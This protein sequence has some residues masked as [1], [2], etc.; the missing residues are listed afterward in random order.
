LA[1]GDSTPT[2]PISSIQDHTVSDAGEVATFLQ[3]TAR[4]DSHFAGKA[5]A[6]IE[7]T[8]SNVDK[9]AQFRKGQKLTNVILTVEAIIDSG[10][11]KIGTDQTHTFS[12]AV[13]MEKGDLQ[14]GNEDSTPATRTVTFALSRFPDAEAD[15]T[16]TIANAS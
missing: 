14:H 2:S 15:P 7:I 4:V 8:T 1:A 6:T 5:A 3:G 12:S 9:V 13:V 16:Y 10:G 11:T